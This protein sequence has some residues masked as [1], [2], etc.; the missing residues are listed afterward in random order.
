MN[1][2]WIKVITVCILLNGVGVREELRSDRR[3]E[4]V[5]LSP[6]SCSYGRPEVCFLY[7][8]ENLKKKMNVVSTILCISSTLC[9]LS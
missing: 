4:E 2:E 7:I 8:A 6:R 3:T 1:I 5:W 9:Y